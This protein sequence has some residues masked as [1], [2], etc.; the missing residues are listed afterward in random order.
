MVEP[1]TKSEMR[2]YL[3][4]K[5]TYSR[6][7]Q[8]AILVINVLF[9][10][11]EITFMFLNNYIIPAIALVVAFPVFLSYSIVK[12]T[13]WIRFS[14]SY[15]SASIV[16]GYLYF[17]FSALFYY[18]VHDFLS[19]YY[20]FGGASVATIISMYLSYRHIK[21]KF[22]NQKIIPKKDSG[23]IAILFSGIIALLSVTLFRDSFFVTLGMRIFVLVAWIVVGSYLFADDYFNY[24]LSKIL[25]ARFY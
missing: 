22:D 9:S 6:K 5:R 12:L 13:R 10:M 17:V 20:Y 7:K 1:L 21:Q 18:L 11:L 19:I 15:R 3:S 25:D 24:R 23:S 4:N 8:I 16:L 14:D 2:R